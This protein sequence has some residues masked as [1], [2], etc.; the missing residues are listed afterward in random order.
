MRK[1]DTNINFIVWEINVDTIFPV[2]IDKIHR[3]IVAEGVRAGAVILVRERIRGCPAGV[4]A[5]DP[6]MPCVNELSS[7]GN[8]QNLFLHAA[9][10]DKISTQDRLCRCLYARFLILSVYIFV[11]G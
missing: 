5:F 1:L 10:P 2:R 3:I 8:L 6:H 4:A 7:V 11:H 9:I